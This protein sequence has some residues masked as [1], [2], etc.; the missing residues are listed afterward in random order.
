MLKR[1]GL[2]QGVIDHNGIMYLW[3]GADAIGRYAVNDMFILDTISLSWRMG[4]LVSAPPPSDDCS[5]ALLPNNNIIYILG[6]LYS[7]EAPFLNKNTIGNAPSN[8]F[9]FS[10]VL[11]LDGQKIIMFGGS[12]KEFAPAP[13][14]ESLYILNS[15]NFE[16]SI[17]NGREFHKANVI[18]AYM[19]ISFG[20]NYDQSVESD[21]LL[22]D[23]RNNDEYVWTYDFDPSTIPVKPATPVKSTQTTQINNDESSNDNKSAMVGVVIRSLVGGVLLSFGGLFLYKWSKN[24]RNQIPTPGNENRN[25]YDREVMLI[26]TKSDIHNHERE[27]VIN[28]KTSD[29]NTNNILENSKIDVYNHGQE[30]IQ[31]PNHGQEVAINEK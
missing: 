9:A 6:D 4:N 14:E 18:G 1:N 17:P 5:A 12:G 19:V 10:I 30:I 7:S 21:I 26:T 28:E 16:W 13:P 23:I 27:A 3:G 11:G 20:G 31:I 2:N 8:R 15:N 24:K 22:L 29:Q 25:N